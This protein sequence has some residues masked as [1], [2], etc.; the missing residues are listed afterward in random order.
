MK[1]I[2]INKRKGIL[3]WITGF[4]GTGKTTVGTLVSQKLGWTFI[5]IDREIEQNAGKTIDSIFSESG[6]DHF[7][8]VETT[9]LAKYA[10]LVN[11]VVSTGG[12][13]PQSYRN[14]QIMA[15]TGFVVCLEAR[16]ETILSRIQQ[17]EL[18]NEELEIR[19]MLE[20]EKGIDR[21]KELK[22]HRQSNYALA[23]WTVHTDGKNPSQVGAEII[24]GWILAGNIPQETKS[25][26]INIASTVRT[27]SGNYAFG[28]AEG[29]YF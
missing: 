23:D 1:K 21:I 29:P 24:N 5:D 3:F 26:Q 16:P 19:P 11:H 18:Q 25:D 22:D 8:S 14:R 4:S 28:L 15:E 9:T 2:K 7:R 6:E 10:K 20:G 27:S 17:Q 13:I 12:G